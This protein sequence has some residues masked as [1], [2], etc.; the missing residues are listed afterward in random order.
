MAE[1]G[2]D[3]TQEIKIH[4]KDE[5]GELASSVNKF[6]ANLRNI[7]QEVHKGAVVVSDTSLQLSSSSQQ[8]SA[9]ANETAAAMT[10]MSAS[11][12]Q[13]NTNIQEIAVASET[14]TEHANEGSKGIN[15]IT[16]QMQTIANSSQEVANSISALSEKSQEIGQ[17]VELITNIADQ[18]NL[19]ALNAAIEAARAGDHGRGFAVVADEVRKLAEE[20]ASAAKEIKNLIGNIQL[21][22]QNAVE[23]IAKGG[24]E[25]DAGLSVVQ[26]V[27]VAF[28]EIINAV[29]GLTSQIED[30]ASAT[31][32]MSSGVQNVAAATEEQTAAMEEVSASAQSLSKTATELNNVVGKFTI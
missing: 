23:S 26:E 32:Q 8:T 6:I 3:L 31:E 16:V 17:I 27:S 12:E 2:G 22:S 11:V 19:L 13:V 18:T 9:S 21:E 25:V 28:V 1:N 7:M 29:Q 15:K 4:S 5:I 20:S 30:V 14:A 24:K 10:E